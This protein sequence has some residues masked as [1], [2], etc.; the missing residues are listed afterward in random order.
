[1]KGGGGAT[2]VLGTRILGKDSK[3]AGSACS[4]GAGVAGKVG[5]GCR[6]QPMG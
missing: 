4:E 1:M 6:S 5:L 2:Q 3:A